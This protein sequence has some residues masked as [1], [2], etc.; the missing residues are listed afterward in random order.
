MTNDF[1]EFFEID[2]MPANPG[3]GVLEFGD[4][5]VAVVDGIP[6]FTPSESYSTGNFSKLREKHEQIQFDSVNGTSDRLETL[7]SRTNWPRE[8]FKGKTVL[9]C[10]CGAGPD[11]EILAQL[12]AK[13]FSI[14]LA[15]VDIAKRN[16]QHHDN[17]CFVQ[18]S[19]ED[20]PLRKE[21]FDIVFC[22]RVIMHTPNPEGIL[23]HILSFVKPNGAVFVHSYSRDFRQMFRWKYLARPFT[24]RMDPEKLYSAISKTAPF[25][26]WLTN[27]MNRNRVT[28]RLA[29]ILV[30]FI[31]HRYKKKFQHLSDEK[32]LEYAIHETFD[33]MSPRYDSPLSRATLDKHARERL[34]QPYEIVQESAVVIL[35][36]IL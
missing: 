30:P 5:K 35:R 17:V 34:Q 23:G 13:V 31:N 18:A 10:G 28:R 20:I 12:G 33:A 26:F 15:G 14:D 19:I 8:Y 9:E 32:M 6:R 16:L 4:R 29:Y 36:T 7:L 22:H 25:L 21:C 3:K 1:L 11:T 24:K 27:I 2:G